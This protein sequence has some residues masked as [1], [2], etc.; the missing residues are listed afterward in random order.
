MSAA[1]FPHRAGRVA[2]GGPGPAGGCL[3]ASSAQAQRT[4][5]AGAPDGR[6]PAEEGG[7][8]GAAAPP[9]GEPPG[10]AELR[11]QPWRADEPSALGAGRGGDRGLGDRGRREAR[12]RPRRA[13]RA[14]AL[15][16]LGV[17][18]PRMEA[19]K[20]VAPRSSLAP[21]LAGLGV[22]DPGPSG[23]HGEQRTL[24]TSEVSAPGDAPHGWEALG[25]TLRASPGMPRSPQV[26]G[27]GGKGALKSSQGLGSPGVTPRDRL[28]EQVLSLPVVVRPTKG[29]S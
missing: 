12:R 23:R 17:G 24:T 25:L 22:A 2:Q 21:T 13:G 16:P 18:G 7:A 6:G 14:E 26:P 19:G 9:P 11:L 29:D 28:E 10:S 27:S 3:R 8:A 5:M 20:G 4:R 1:G 15:T